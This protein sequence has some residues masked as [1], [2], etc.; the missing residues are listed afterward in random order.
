MVVFVPFKADHLRQINVQP[1]Q[2]LQAKMLLSNDTEVLEN[3]DSWTAIDD[4]TVI[5][6]SGIMVAPGWPTRGYLWSIL[7]TDCK[8]RMVRIVRFMKSV[9]DSHPADRVEMTVEYDFTEGHRL[10]HILGFVCEA[11]LMR[12]WGINGED[13]TQY[14]KVREQ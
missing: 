5:A 4:G 10:A 1:A 3:N 11:P 12:K 14:A 6:C 13:M 7:S 2:R 9:I 8:P